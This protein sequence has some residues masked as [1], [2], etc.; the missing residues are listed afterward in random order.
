MDAV[1][2]L[3]LSL[4]LLFHFIFRFNWSIIALQ[5]VLASAVDAAGVSVHTDPSS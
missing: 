5:S 2:F 1:D 4:Q 3:L